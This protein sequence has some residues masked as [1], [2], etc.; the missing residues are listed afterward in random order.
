MCGVAST[1]ECHH[2]LTCGHSNLARGQAMLGVT[3]FRGNSTEHEDHTHTR[4]YHECDRRPKVRCRN[5]IMFTFTKRRRLPV[6]GHDWTE[7]LRVG[8]D[9][10]SIACGNHCRSTHHGADVSAGVG[11]DLPGHSQRRCVSCCCQGSRAHLP[12]CATLHVELR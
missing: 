11:S 10:H 6:G 4:R 9:E 7:H 1:S 12:P 8:Q 5:P 3:A 2:N